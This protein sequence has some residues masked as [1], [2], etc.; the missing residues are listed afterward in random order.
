MTATFLLPLIDTCQTHLLEHRWLLAP[1][2]RVANQWKDQINLSGINTVNL[3]AEALQS[4]VIGLVTADIAVRGLEFATDIRCSLA[5]FDP[6]SSV[7]ETRIRR[8]MTTV[9]VSQK[10]VA[11]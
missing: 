9:W 7:P 4:A 10:T 6:R 3:H 2:R 5:L 1:D 8:L 11:F